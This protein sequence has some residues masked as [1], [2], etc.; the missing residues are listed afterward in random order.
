MLRELKI[1]LIEHVYFIV[2]ASDEPLDLL[3][4]VWK[5]L[6]ECLGLCHLFDVHVGLLG[7]A[8]DFEDVVHFFTNLLL[9]CLNFL[10]NL[11]KKHLVK[12]VELL[13]QTLFEIANSGHNW[14]N[15]Q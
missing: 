4:L 5:L 12:L 15:L 3:H 9:A 10:L 2:D 7:L 11:L 13:F 6:E 1:I 14:S 8:D